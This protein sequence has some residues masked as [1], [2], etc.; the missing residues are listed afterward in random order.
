M[1]RCGFGAVEDMFCRRGFCFVSNIVP[2]GAWSWTPRWAQRDDPTELG[3]RQA[4]CE[5]AQAGGYVTDTSLQRIS[6]R[7][8]VSK[9]AGDDGTSSRDTFRCREW[10]GYRIP[11]HYE[12]DV[13]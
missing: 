6:T 9:N 1:C 4:G 2:C 3:M 13:F 10:V 12:H 5:V 8:L 7:Y 11:G